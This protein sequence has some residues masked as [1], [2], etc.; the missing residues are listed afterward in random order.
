MAML[1]LGGICY[2]DFKERKVYW[3]IFPILGLLL[4]SLYFMVSSEP[5]VPFFNIVLNI[6]L[7]GTFLLISYLHAKL[8]MKRKFVDHSLGWGDI[9]L[10]LALALG[11]PTITFT[12][13]LVA[14]LIFHLLAFLAVKS[15]LKDPMVPLAGLMGLFYATILA[16]SIFFA[17]PSLYQY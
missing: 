17:N 6:L 3:V 13:L 14:A 8:I 7:V 9:L 5:L 16:Y 2:Q 4:G 15:K 11:F 12:L 10:F 1:C